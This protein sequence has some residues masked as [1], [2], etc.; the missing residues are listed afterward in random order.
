MYCTKEVIPILTSSFPIWQRLYLAEITSGVVNGQPLADPQQWPDTI[1]LEQKTTQS[2]EAPLTFWIFRQWNLSPL[3]LTVQTGTYPLL[4]VCPWASR[5][6]SLYI[7]SSSDHRGAHDSS[8][9]TELLERIR[10][11]IALNCFT[12]CPG[13]ANVYKTNKNSVYQFA[14]AAITKQHR[15]GV[16]NDRSVLSP[17]SGGWKSK[18]RVLAGWGPS[19][20]LGNNL[21]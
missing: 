11:L 8:C 13:H 20:G 15:L 9:L 3:V 7:T 21:F 5:L 10:E 1:V 4:A 6:P 16:L 17:S 18:I 19:E 2:V 14:R 12:S